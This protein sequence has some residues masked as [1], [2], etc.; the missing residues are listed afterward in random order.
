[1]RHILPIVILFFSTGCLQAGEEKKEPVLTGLDVLC[2]EDF[3]PLHGLRV[4]LITNHTGVD[5]RGRSNIG[6]FARSSEL[7]LAAL[8]TPEHGLDGIIEGEY[9]AGNLDSLQL[10]VYS[11]YGKVRKPEKVWLAGLDALVFDIQ[12]IGARFYTYIT[13]LA[14]CMQAA[15]EA[16]IGF[17]VLD[18][19][20][21]VGGTKVEG[22]VLE[23][24]LQGN[25]IAFYPIP[26]RHGMTVGELARLFN[27]EFGIR[28]RLE[29]IPMQGW[30]RKMYSDQTGLQWINPSP[31]M[32]SLEAA[33]LY[34]GLGLSEATNLSVGR[35]T[36]LPFELYGA[37]YVDGKKLSAALKAHAI[38]GLVYRDT[39]FTPQAY[40][41]KGE[42]CEGVRAVVTDRDSL[43]S[44]AAGL[45]LLGVLKSLYPDSFDLSRIDLWIG[46]REV[47]QQLGEG[48]PAEQI[49]QSWQPELVRFKILREKYLLYDP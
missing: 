38:A 8:F 37:P 2:R 34:P 48:M 29:V 49:I 7:K 27:A 6:L 15:S 11:L 24:E 33:I 12:D 47:K 19:P 36:D 17:Y 28:V 42:R 31:N 30:R 22:P 35:G 14:L 16:K 1:M 20:N 21:P 23:Q 39:V 5:S 40:Q 9:G 26:I 3:A 18:R 45:E 25:F 10:P 44:V 13:T 46:R 32:R 41:F 43:E 4:G